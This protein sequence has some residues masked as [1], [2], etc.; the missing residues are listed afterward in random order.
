MQLTIAALRTLRVEQLAQRAPEPP[1]CNSYR[2]APC[3]EW[4]FQSPTHEATAE[5]PDDQEPVIQQRPNSFSNPYSRPTFCPVASV[6]PKRS[7]S[8]PIIHPVRSP[9]NNSSSS[10]PT[11][12]LL[13]EIDRE[14]LLELSRESHHECSSWFT[15]CKQRVML[16][17]SETSRTPQASV[18][19]SARQHLPA[20]LHRLTAHA[21]RSRRYATLRVL[22][23]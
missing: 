6:S 3:A 18:L 20:R 21:P 11:F 13:R 12:E 9:E 1:P 22:C 10:R 2:P 23:I 5:H 19:T 8:R 17:V 15:V 7:P 16:S 4:R 14:R